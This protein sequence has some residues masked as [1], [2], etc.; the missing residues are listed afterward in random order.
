MEVK[1]ILMVMALALILVLA[2]YGLFDAAKNKGEEGLGEFKDRAERDDPG[3]VA[4]E[5]EEV[6]EPL[7]KVSTTVSARSV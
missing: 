7:E 6:N 4:L 3:F 2:L 1:D 5:K